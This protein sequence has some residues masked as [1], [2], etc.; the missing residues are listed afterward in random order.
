MRRRR[1]AGTTVPSTQCWA[2]RGV[3]CLRRL[4]SG[5]AAGAVPALCT[6][7]SDA[8]APDRRPAVGGQPR[9]QHASTVEPICLPAPLYRCA[10]ACTASFPAQRAPPPA[11]VRRA[12]RMHRS[13]AVQHRSTAAA[14]P[15]PRPVTPVTVSPCCNLSQ[16]SYAHAWRVHPEHAHPTR[17]PR[18]GRPD[19]SAGAPEVAR[20]RARRRF[21]DGSSRSSPRYWPLAAGR[22]AGRARRRVGAC[23]HARMHSRM[24]HKSARQ[25]ARLLAP[26]SSIL[27]TWVEARPPARPP[28]AGGPVG[29]RA[30]GR[31]PA[32]SPSLPTCCQLP[33][34]CLLPDGRDARDA[35]RFRSGARA[36]ARRVSARRAPAPRTRTCA[37]GYLGTWPV[38]LYRCCCTCAPCTMHLG[39]GLGCLLSANNSQSRCGC[40]CAAV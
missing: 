1:I 27:E 39:L 37:P 28:A 18:P 15:R 29:Q 30:S 20:A 13:S 8:P 7:V 40:R 34:A 12:R 16:T 4:A 6:V 24:Q 31:P 9:T 10:P 23:T 25:A 11:G 5:T 19:A 32:G 14:R 22:W 3:G 17:D 36:A 33:A 35:G 2:A 38:Y 26:P 21:Q